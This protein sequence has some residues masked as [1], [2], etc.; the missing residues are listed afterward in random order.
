MRRA[1]RWIGRWGIGAALAL[2][3]A[4]TVHDARAFSARVEAGLARADS[5]QHA[6]SFEAAFAVLDSLLAVANAREDA[7]LRVAATLARARAL[8]NARR[9]DDAAREVRAVLPEVQARRDTL[10]LCR[11]WR[12][13]ARADE[14]LGHK[15]EARAG[16]TRVLAL[17]RHARLR[18]EEAWARVALAGMDL[19]EGRQDDAIRGY[20]LAV[21]RFAGTGDVSGSF[22][23]RAGLARAL[24]ES[25]R[26]AEARRVHRVLLDDAHRRGDV[27]AE[28]Q[29]CANLGS[30]E[31]ASGDPAAAA[32]LFERALAIYHAMGALP[33]ELWAVNALGTLYLNQGRLDEAD[34][35]LTRAL[36][37]ALR[38]PDPE[39]R[40]RAL[41]Q[42]GVL[43]RTQNR[44]GEAE[45]LGRRAVAGTDSLR[46]QGIPSLVLPLVGTL[47]RMGRLEM[48]VAL[49]DSQLVRVGGR[50]TPAGHGSLTFRR[51]VLLR[52]LGRPEEALEPL[53]AAAATM[54]GG[55]GGNQGAQQLLDLTELARCYS[56]LGERDS[57]LVW[58][59]RIAAQWESWRGTTSDARWR[60]TY[61]DFSRRFSGEYAAALLDT[62]R[63]AGSETRAR[64]AFDALQRFRA[65]TLA[66]RISAPGSDAPPTLEIVDSHAA[67]RSLAPG[68]L[69]MDIHATGDTTFVFVLT[70]GV[71]RAYGLRAAGS[72]V[73]R[74]RR[75][76]DAAAD[77]TTDPHTLADASAILGGE[78]LG[79][80]ADLIAT[81]RRVVIAAGP[82]AQY[83]LELLT[84][85][86]AVH[87]LIHDRECAWVPSAARLAASRQTRPRARP[88][89]ILAVATSGPATEAIPG[90]EREAVWLT[91]RFAASD[92]M[93]EV[94]RRPAAVV[95][96]CAAG[97]SVLHIAAHTRSGGTR[98]WQDAIRV[99]R[100]GSDTDWLTAAQIAHMR[101][102]PPL[103]VL[104]G[105]AS[106][107]DRVGW[108]ETMDGLATAWIAAGARAVIATRWAV[109]DEATSVLMRA[110]YTRLAR[111]ETAGAALR[112]AQLKLGGQ[113]RFA[114]PYYWAGV[115]LLGDPDM[116]VSLKERH[117]SVASAGS[118]TPGHR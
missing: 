4:L 14:L 9:P 54:L 115:L 23:A 65:R 79:P 60:E 95:E 32:P 6:G 45:A 28:A 66:E 25:G 77:A 114:H 13:L 48:A 50:L 31:L 27:F 104:A 40:A 19:D 87:S 111:G 52:K 71:I 55:A 76:R 96:S 67:Q 86:G 29:T 16:Y 57:A 44:L 49:L 42:M 51:A 15:P 12:Y 61:D 88:R 72:L 10:A 2:S 93:S 26:T 8:L 80:A 64:E 85:P 46:P 89:A 107:G 74:L 90:A 70:S 73:P 30:L 105:C 39:V 83:P 11:A 91:G 109:D 112:E 103:C 35:V 63:A 20:R 94:T 92:R 82:V 3:L 100:T 41:C 102:I 101:R 98:P 99:S 117:G 47:E 7:G 84:A 38:S 97:Y 106:L 36:P 75:L 22:A 53:R 58:Y 43:R 69:L 18:A 59:R 34:S 81:A 116:R 56:D 24:Q 62:G 110:F 5:L 21:S 33:L 113:S 37:W 118:A 78:M 17:A 68:E 1:P 108:G